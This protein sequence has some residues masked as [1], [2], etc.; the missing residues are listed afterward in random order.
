[1]LRVVAELPGKPG[2]EARGL[3]PTA[4]MAPRAV[5]AIPARNEA[6]HL[7]ACLR[8]LADQR[9]PAGALIATPLFEVIVF[10]NDCSDGTAEHA[11]ALAAQLPFAVTVVE[12]RLRAGAAHAGEARRTAMNLALARLEAIGAA[13]SVILTTDADSRVPPNWIHGNFA[14]IDA[15]AD[16][17]LGRL[18]LDEDGRKL[19]EALH[20]RGALESEYETLLAEV[21]ATLDPVSHNPWPHHSTISGA[22]VAVTA[23]AYRRIGGLPRVALG[24]DKA[25]VAELLRRDARVRFDNAI[26]VV[27]SARLKGRAIGGVAD[28]LRLRARFPDSSCDDA[29]ESYRAAETRAHWR[30]RLRRLWADKGAPRARALAAGLA[31][32][33]LEAE[34]IADEQ[35]FGAAWAIAERRSPLLHRRLLRPSDLPREIAAAREGLS[36]L[37]LRL[38]ATSGGF[39]IESGEDLAAMGSIPA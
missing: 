22:S 33:T 38:C 18:A 20:R 39:A 29:L 31:I 25:L 10:A 12:G 26:E 24:E 28:T 35:A 6:H 32:P 23:E 27:T 5:V 19:P 9:T 14:A 17:V 2:T 37:K 3:A 11:R 13:R 30:G 16:A 36:R 8:A 21:F 7:P 15:G 34:R 1:M 4:A